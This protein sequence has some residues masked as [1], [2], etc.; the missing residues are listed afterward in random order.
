VR[1]RL[2][3]EH[4][5]GRA[6]AAR[7]PVAPAPDVAAVLRL[8][9]L[10]GNAAVTRMLAREEKAR[11]PERTIALEGLGSGPIVAFM[12]AGEHGFRVT[13]E[14]GPLGPKL[15]QAATRGDPI[16]SVTIAAAGHAYTLNQVSVASFQVGGTPPAIVVEL[17]GASLHVE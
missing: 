2:R 9:A 5:E 14:D 4:P 1:D 13:L 11:A 3:R 7:A 8:Q 16:P 15:Q 12:T 6:E 10:A 17:Q